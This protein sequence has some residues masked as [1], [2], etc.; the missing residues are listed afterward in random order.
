VID[1]ADVYIIDE[2]GIVI[3][4]TYIGDIGL[5]LKNGRMYMK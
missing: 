2:N 3:D 1:I 4:A 5:I